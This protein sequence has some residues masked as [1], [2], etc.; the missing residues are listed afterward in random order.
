MA[1]M[2]DYCFQVYYAL[3]IIIEDNNNLLHKICKSTYYENERI[4]I[5][6]YNFNR[7]GINKY[8]P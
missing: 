1:S 2:C 7:R 3:K 8:E 4:I 5:A 6:T